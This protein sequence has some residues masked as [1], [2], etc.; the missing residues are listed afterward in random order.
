MQHKPVQHALSTHF[1]L[2]P[3]RLDFIARFT[4]ALL[5][6]RTVNL[7][8]IALALSGATQPESNSKRARRFLEFPLAQNLIAQFILSFVRNE[9][10]VLCMDRTNW[11]FGSVT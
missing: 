8:R 6:V 10:I 4:I 5:K 11:K 1:S 7:N 9:R 2:D 3:R